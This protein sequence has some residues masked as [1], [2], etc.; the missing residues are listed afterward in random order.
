M[1]RSLHALLGCFVG[2]A[3][4]ASSHFA[5]AAKPK[6]A[7]R[8]PPRAPAAAD[9]TPAQPAAPAAPVEVTVVEIAGDR[10]YV[11]PG[12][13]A[14]LVRGST[15][16]LHGRSFTV[17]EASDSFA[18]IALSDDR[19]REEEKG[20]VARIGTEED[21]TVELPKPRPLTKW[22]HA[23]EPAVAPADSQH[24]AF[25]PLGAEDGEGR[26]LDVRLTLLAGA[27]LPLSS[28]QVGTGIAMGELNAQVHAA[29]LGSP[30][31]LDV[32][33]SLRGWA[34]ADLASR[35]GG[36]TRSS[37]YVREL[38]ASYTAGGFYAGVG[39]MR[40]AAS[41]LGTLDGGRAHVDVGDGFTLGAF[42]GVLPNPMS[43]ELSLDAQRFGVEARYSRPDL[44]WRPEA[45]L[46]AHGSMFQGALDERRLS[47]V[48]GAYPGDSRLGAYFEV[49][50]FGAG[51]PWNEP[52]LALTAAG[53]DPS[54]RI[55]PVTLGARFDVRQPEISRWMASFLPQSWLCRTVPSSG[56]NPSAPE[57][58]DGSPSLRA[59]SELDASVE[60]DRLSFVLGGTTVR[61]LQQS[62]EAD[63]VG[64]FA[65]A[66]VV[67]LA[68]ILRLE[69]SGSFSRATYLDMFGGTM[70]PGLTL[71][72]DVLDVSTYYRLSVL[73]YRSVDSS[74]TQ[75]GV[76]ATV[77]FF[78]NA[79]VLF[80]FQ[81]EGVTGDDVQAVT[82][83]G[84]VS[85]R[86]RF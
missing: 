4:L 18:V 76:G 61:E 10:A 32:D 20:K 67:R 23:W 73:K 57:P 7:P 45:S 66:R 35:V 29:P 19:L 26:A 21:K 14:G 22:E 17:F 13:K 68:R 84:T 85:W 54:V 2:L 52:T 40:Y 1:T 78:P 16:T 8:P 51:N 53:V 6:R 69:A 47:G 41:T 42:G 75:N 36:P 82:L 30:F 12:A 64:G 38:L 49:S 43:G 71:L 63:M 28:R 50:N 5:E 27:N 80:T 86:P 48:F 3:V 33:A 83:F 79:S 34:A 62:N 81:G 56:A 55:G 44:A 77:A 72:D 25:V 60:I 9:A 37:L 39:R 65:S 46:V 59:F 70:G 74:L 24:P 31:R 15:V 11:R 58:C